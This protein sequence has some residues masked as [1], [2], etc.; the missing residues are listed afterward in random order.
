MTGHG[1]TGEI[2]VRVMPLVEQDTN[3]E[4][5]Q[6]LVIIMVKT[7]EQ[8]LVIKHVMQVHVNHHHITTTG[9][10]EIPQVLTA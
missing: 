1:Q 10:V 3:I 2:G 7:V 4:V 8:I 6:K 5:E 9:V